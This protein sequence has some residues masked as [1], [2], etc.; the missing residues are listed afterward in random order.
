MQI[1]LPFNGIDVQLLSL[2]HENINKKIVINRE[3]IF[4]RFIT[5][6]FLNYFNFQVFSLQVSQ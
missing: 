2:L 5:S 3:I 6:L 1:P 4:N